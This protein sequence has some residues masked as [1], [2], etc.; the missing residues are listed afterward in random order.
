MAKDATTTKA[1]A[2]A[3]ADKPKRRTLTAEE[4]IAKLEAEARAIREKAEARKA[5]AR[6]SEMEKRAKLVERRDKLN[7]QIAAIDAVYPPVEAAEV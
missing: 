6:A 4:R 5:A 3:K 1:E 7:E 2:P